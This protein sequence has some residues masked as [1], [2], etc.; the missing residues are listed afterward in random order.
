MRAGAGRAIDHRAVVDPKRAAEQLRELRAR[1]VGGKRREETEAA[2]VH[3]DDRHLLARRFV[4]DAE[5]RA[6]A[7]DDAA[8][9]AAAE[10]A[11]RNRETRGLFRGDFRRARD[12]GEFP[13]E[14][15]GAVLVLIDDEREM[16]ERWHRKKGGTLIFANF[17]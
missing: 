13:R 14:R 8:G 6:V 17:R 10:P 7:A 4:R 15:R 2:A 12:G 9:V 3:P 16:A 5:Q 11:L 1:L